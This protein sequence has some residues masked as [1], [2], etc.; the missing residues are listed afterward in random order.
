LMEPSSASEPA[1]R[2]KARENKARENRAT[3]TGA[4]NEY[5]SQ[6]KEIPCLYFPSR[7]SKTIS[8]N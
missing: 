7:E 5:R 6:L 8:T 3:P 1:D 4:E 2:N